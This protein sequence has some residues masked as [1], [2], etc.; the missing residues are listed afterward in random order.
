MNQTVGQDGR[1]NSDDGAQTREKPLSFI[2]AN[3]NRNLD[4]GETHGR[5]VVAATVYKPRPDNPP[6]GF[7]IQNTRLAVFGDST[8]FSNGAFL[9]F[10]HKDFTLN[11]VRWLLG[12][13]EELAGVTGSPWTERILSRSAGIRRFLFWVPIFVFPGIVLCI[14]VFVYL[15]RKS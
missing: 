12:L 3:G 10:S 8:F 11:T 14:G 15:L 9:R 1:G 5:I 7:E 2:D 4:K 13:E 6:P